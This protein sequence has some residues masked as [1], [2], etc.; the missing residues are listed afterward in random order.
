MVGFSRVVFHVLIS[1][2]LGFCFC[3]VNPI[4]NPA[5]A[6]GPI[7]TYNSDKNSDLTSKQPAI[8][9]SSIRVTNDY[10]RLPEYFIVN[11]G[12]A[13]E[14]VRI[15]MEGEKQT[16]FSTNDVKVV[17]EEGP[18]KINLLLRPV[19]KGDDGSFEAANEEVSASQRDK[20]NLVAGYLATV[21]GP[22]ELSFY[23]KVSCEPSG[24]YLEVTL[25]GEQLTKISGEIDWH[26]KSLTIP[27][28]SHTLGWIYRRD[29][30]SVSGDDCGWLDQV[31]FIT[32]KTLDNL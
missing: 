15:H 22:G 6:K 28:G 5:L 30:N 10:G 9:G 21:T 8:A 29:G 31:E 25:N 13:D 24:A 11:R 17:K 19:T 16:F 20:A 23:W 26:L 4:V 32:T 3:L 2:V 14:H 27:P 12:Q 7:G 1:P 18:S